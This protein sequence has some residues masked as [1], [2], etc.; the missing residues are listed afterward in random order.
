MLLFES[1][2]KMT[3]DFGTYM[4]SVPVFMQIIVFGFMVSVLVKLIRVA[5]SQFNDLVDIILN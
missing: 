1:F 4:G 3:M 2:Y 5:H